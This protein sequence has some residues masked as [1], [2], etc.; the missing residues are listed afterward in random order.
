MIKVLVK[1]R[2]K[3]EQLERLKKVSDEYEFV[4]EDDKDVEIILGNYKAEKLKEFKNLKWIQTSAVGVDNYIKK[5]ILNDDTILTN[6]VD[7]HSKEVAEHIFAMMIALVKK[8]HT[9][10]D[11]QNKHLWKDE[12]GV[13]EITNLKVAIVGFGDIGREFAKLCKS[14]GMYVIGVKQT[15]IEL[16]EYLD[17][18]YLS[19]DLNKA[20]SNVDVVVSV[21]PGIKQNH[22]LF[23]LDTFKAMRNDCVFVNAGRGNLYSEEVLKQVLEEKIIKAVAADVFEKEPIDENNNLWDYENLLIT[24]HAAGFFHLESALD[25]FVDL[26][27]ENLR[28]YINKEELLHVVKERE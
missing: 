14:L 22:H 18:L 10:R 16:P 21:L 11:N 1:S 8:L 27:E 19:K 24:P 7:V 26:I 28:R 23:T 20:I 9:Y 15:P 4:Y 2:F 6:A 5:G 17:E 12:G 13:K 25:K 3:D